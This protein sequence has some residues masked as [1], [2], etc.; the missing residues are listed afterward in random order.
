MRSFKQFVVISLAAVLLSFG[1]AYAQSGSQQ[2]IER[3]V[4]K[5]I[6]KLP[7]YEVFDYIG[8]EVNGDTVTLTGKVL[9]GTNRKAAERSVREIPGVS[10]VVNNIEIL[11]AG[12]Y[13][14]RIRRSLYAQLSR[15]GGLSRYLWP[16]NPSVRLIVDNGHISL[17]GYVATRG[18][19]N[20]MNVVAHGVSGAFTVTNNLKVDSGRA[21]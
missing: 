4:Q 11:P 20:A 19:Y 12:S 9:N 10:R 17:E 14:E 5:K 21:N 18:D 1:S 3:Q 15:T 6:L 8:Y 13:D 2:S 7:Y 16:T